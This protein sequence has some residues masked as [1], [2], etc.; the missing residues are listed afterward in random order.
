[1]SLKQEQE[2]KQLEE[3]QKIVQDHFIR[4]GQILEYGS[5]NRDMDAAE[6]AEACFKE[7]YNKLMHLNLSRENRRNIK[8]LKNALEYAIK[9]AEELKKGRHNKAINFMQI[10]SEYANRYTS[11]ILARAKKYEY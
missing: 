2:I 7:G 6:R 5:E 9:S 1:M 3:L 4:G 10:S 8:L 11:V